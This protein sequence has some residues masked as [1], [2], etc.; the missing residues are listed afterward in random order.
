VRGTSRQREKCLQ[1]P[2]ERGDA[3]G[4]QPPDRQQLG[5]VGGGD[6]GDR[7]EPA[8]EL[9][10]DWWRDA[11]HEREECGR[12][13]D[14]GTTRPW[15][16]SSPK[17]GLASE[18]GLQPRSRQR[19][20]FDEQVANVEGRPQRRSGATSGHFRSSDEGR[21]PTSVRP[22]TRRRRSRQRSDPGTRPRCQTIG[23]VPEPPT[24]A[25]RGQRVSSTRRHRRASSATKPLFSVP[26]PYQV[27]RRH[28]STVG[29]K[30]P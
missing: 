23:V 17:L 29:R 10:C 15:T 11:G 20:S 2:F 27:M 1:D 4:S 28:F 18:D 8:D 25:R 14:T 24:T 30:V 26:N 6:R 16:R 3:G 19:A 5:F 22:H 21:P 9:R 12:A 7:S 13:F